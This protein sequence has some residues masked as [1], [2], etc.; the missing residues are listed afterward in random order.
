[1]Q[2]LREK[3]S[4]AHLVSIKVNS[5][6]SESEQIVQLTENKRKSLQQYL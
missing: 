4:P 5:T 6:E 1:M 3:I 2:A